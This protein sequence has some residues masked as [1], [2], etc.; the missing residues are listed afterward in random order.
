MHSAFSILLSLCLLTFMFQDFN[1]SLLKYICLSADNV[2]F[3]SLAGIPGFSYPFPNE[4]GKI[5]AYDEL[6]S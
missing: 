1:I 2:I 6:K 5:L 4:S 3:K